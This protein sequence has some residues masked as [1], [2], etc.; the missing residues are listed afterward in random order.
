MTLRTKIG[1][2]M[3]ARTIAIVPIA[4]QEEDDVSGE[5]SGEGEE[6]AEEQLNA[7]DELDELADEDYKDVEEVD[8][9]MK[10]KAK[11][12]P[13]N[14]K[15]LLI[16]EIYR[17]HL[18]SQ[19]LTGHISRWSERGGKQLHFLSLSNRPVSRFMFFRFLITY[20]QANIQGSKEWTD[21]TEANTTLDL[22]G[23]PSS[24]EYLE[25]NTL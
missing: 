8:V 1:E 10:L 18:F 17:D 6:K 5:E 23:L 11:R 7:L 9:K 22:W 4:S 3:D 21:K 24:G 12:H 20:L 15:W 13:M 2:A 25:K 16:K 14:W 19:D